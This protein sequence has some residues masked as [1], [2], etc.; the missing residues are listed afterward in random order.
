MFNKTTSASVSLVLSTPLGHERDARAITGFV[1]SY[2]SD[3]GSFGLLY[4]WLDKRR[5]CGPVLLEHKIFQDTS[6]TLPGAFTRIV[7]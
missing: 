2:G 6:A 3:Q 1:F 7:R 4:N 5:A